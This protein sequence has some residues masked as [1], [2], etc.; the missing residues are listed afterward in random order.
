MRAT[1]PRFEDFAKLRAQLDPQGR[2]L[3]PYLRALFEVA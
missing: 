3:N 1:Y 2:L